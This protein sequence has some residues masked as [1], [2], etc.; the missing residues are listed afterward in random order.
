VQ[1]GSQQQKGAKGAEVRRKGP[2]HQSAVQEPESRM[3]ERFRGSQCSA[4]RRLGT[5]RRN[6]SRLQL[7]QIKVTK[8]SYIVDIHFIEIV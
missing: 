7:R 8:L 1:R 5:T 3:V 2:H 4:R 6:G